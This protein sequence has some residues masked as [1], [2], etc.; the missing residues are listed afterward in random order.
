[1]TAVQPFIFDGT[2]VVR[3]LVRDGDPWFVA[4]DVA[5][6]LGYGNP[7][8][9]V[10]DH[11]KGGRETRLPSSGGEQ[12]TKIIPES[13]VYR[14]IMRSNLPSAERFQDWVCED[15]LPSIRRTGGY[16]LAQ[17]AETA[18]LLQETERELGELKARRHAINLEIRRLE[19]RRLRLGGE[20]LRLPWSGESRL[21]VEMILAEIPA[22][23]I[24]VEALCRA[25]CEKHS[26]SRSWFYRLWRKIR[27]DGLVTD[28]PDGQ[29][30]RA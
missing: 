5:R 15:V 24:R 3:T 14:L 21:T 12:E 20:P 17:G 10:L 2:L 1:M 27:A 25:V 23:G 6:A 22:E 28:L 18:F 13:D 8:Q 26:L 30:T 4:I 7:R 9:A 11:T 16:F 19:K 29:V